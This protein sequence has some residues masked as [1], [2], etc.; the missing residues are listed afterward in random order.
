MSRLESELCDIPEATT[1]RLAGANNN[2]CAIEWELDVWAWA[3]EPVAMSVT[4]S[5]PGCSAA[6]VDLIALGGRWWIEA[7][8]TLPFGLGSTAWEDLDHQLARLS[9]NARA[10]FCG[11]RQPRVVVA[12][13]HEC[14]ADVREALSSRGAIVVCAGEDGVLPDA[15]TLACTADPTG[16]LAFAPAASSHAAVLLD[17]T[18][19]LALL[20]SSC[21]APPADARLREWASGNEHWARSLD[22]EAASPLLPRLCGLL[23]SHRPWLAR[24]EDV[25][26]CDELVE[27]AGGEAE[28]ARWGALRPSLV[29]PA[30]VR[31]GG[32]P[33]T[34]GGADG[35]ADGGAA[36]ARS[37]GGVA[38]AHR[39]LLVEGALADAI[40][41]TAN[42]RLLRRVPEHVHL[43]AHVHEARWL[44]GD[45][46]PLEPEEASCLAAD[47]TSC[48]R[49]D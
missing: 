16:S 29:D 23:Q 38:A 37:L 25:A 5:P 31:A 40:L 20:S 15:A 13:R 28:R 32:A 22:E 9:R 10:S 43:R 47:P 3:P 42:G 27:M 33:C 44:V 30:A 14:G 45:A 49:V 48:V 2:L 12:F 6:T 1:S 7:K 11:T 24:R 19:M 26:R 4:T 46:L 8:A 41:C 34:R 39:Q 21:R 18:T 36:L 17:V 35:G